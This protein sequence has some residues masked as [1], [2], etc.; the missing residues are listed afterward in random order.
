MNQAVVQARM[1]IQD[2]RAQAYSHLLHQLQLYSFRMALG[3]F[4]GRS[5]SNREEALSMASFT[6]N[7]FAMED[8]VV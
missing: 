7:V 8:P 1:K 2:V 5:A 6:R 4:L 3:I